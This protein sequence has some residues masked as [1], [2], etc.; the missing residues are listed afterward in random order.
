MVSAMSLSDPPQVSLPSHGPPD[1][2]HAEERATEAALVAKVRAGD[3]E[4]FTALV[5]RCIASV[6]RVAYWWTRSHDMAEDIAQNV[7]VRVWE[8]RDML[9]PT[10]PITPFLLRLVRNLVVDEH[11][12]SAARQRRHESV[13]GEQLVSG[14]QVP[15]PE[16]AVLEIATM[17]AALERLSGR[18]QLILRLWLREELSFTD[19]ADILGISVEAAD[20]LLRRARAD[21]RALIDG[22]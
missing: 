1:R 13:V 9:D 14:T 4:A 6:T 16:N 7:F 3:V 12:S 15:S 20:R 8:H 17:D 21:L 19:I 10:R 11:R 5:E 2:A 22:S 18:R